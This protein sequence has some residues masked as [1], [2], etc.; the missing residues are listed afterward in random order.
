MAIRYAGIEFDT[1]EELVRY[2]LLM[3]GRTEKKVVVVHE[4]AKPKPINHEFVGRI[5]KNRGGSK[6]KVTDEK[7]VDFIKSIKR[8]L[9]LTR[10][11]QKLGYKGG[12]QAHQ[13]QR[14]E[15]LIADN[16]LQDRIKRNKNRFVAMP[17]AEIPMKAIR[18]RLSENEKNRIRDMGRSGVSL[19]QIAKQTGRSKASVY[20]LCKD[21][22]K[23]RRKFDETTTERILRG[24]EEGKSFGQI[25]KEIGMSKANVHH[26]YMNH[27]KA[28]VPQSYEQKC[29][30]MAEKTTSYAPFPELVMNNGML[31]LT[32]QDLIR[33]HIA[34]ITAEYAE[35]FGIPNEQE[36]VGFL[37][38]FMQQSSQIAK[39]FNVPNKFVLEQNKIVFRG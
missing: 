6:C 37:L 19:K 13:K 39:H 33:H 26:R 31:R 3:E 5:G 12:M 21:F 36:W 14:L 2:K 20:Q 29:K 28:F 8:K 25:G 18:T 4:Q 10:V 9:T 11:F 23:K 22:I 35:H 27:R 30:Q 1:V 16:N 7:I 38:T 17:Q 32:T 24:R 15:K 34:S